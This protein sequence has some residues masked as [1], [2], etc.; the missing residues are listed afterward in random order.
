MAKAT[1]NTKSGAVITI[2]GSATEVSDLISLV[3]RGSV[4]PRRRAEAVGASTVAADEKRTGTAD[5]V[6]DLKAD[7]FFEKAKALGEVAGALEEKGFLIPVTTLSGVMLGLVQK[8]Q[9]RRK[10]HEGRWVYGK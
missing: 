9:L 6:L 5:L 3:E 7:G 1:I 2:E 8:R 10:R 4:E